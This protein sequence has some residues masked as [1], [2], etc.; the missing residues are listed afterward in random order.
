MSFTYS[1]DIASD[2]PMEFVADVMS[3]YSVVSMSVIE[4]IGPGGGNPFIEFTF[5]SEADL[6]KFTSD[7]EE[8]E[9][10]FA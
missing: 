1:F 6:V 4:A 8:G 10:A 9:G 3:Q 2:C 7:Y 5:A